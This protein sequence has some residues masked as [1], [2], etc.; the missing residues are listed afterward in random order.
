MLLPY[1]PTSLSPTPRHGL[2]S[3]RSSRPSS[4]RRSTR[5]NHR[6][7]T[8]SNNAASSFRSDSSRSEMAGAATVL[9]RADRPDERY[10]PN[11]F[12]NPAGRDAE[13]LEQLFRLSAA[14]YFAHGEA[15]HDVA[16][17]GDRRGHRI[18]DAA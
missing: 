8:G 5:C 2:R 3:S 1:G 12:D 15:M 17:I 16:G 11:R 14:R 13:A 7:R 9:P 6:W 18:A 4:R 10:R